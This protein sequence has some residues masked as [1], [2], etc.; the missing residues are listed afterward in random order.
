[1]E[2]AVAVVE[3]ISGDGAS[4]GGEFVGIQADPNAISCDMRSVDGVGAGHQEDGAMSRGIGDVSSWQARAWNCSSAP[5]PSTTVGVAAVG[6]VAAG[7]I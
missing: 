2:V 4:T 7:T 6:S 3:A 5:P 1:V